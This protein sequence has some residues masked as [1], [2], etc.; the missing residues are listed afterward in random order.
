MLNYTDHAFM[1]IYSI[2]MNAVR[3]ARLVFQI[4]R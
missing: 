2:E 1:L 4:L 3:L